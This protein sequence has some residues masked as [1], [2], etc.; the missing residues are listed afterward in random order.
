MKK[1]KDLL[2]FTSLML[3]FTYYI[4]KKNRDLKNDELFNIKELLKEFP[5][6]NKNFLTFNPINDNTTFIISNL[7]DVSDIEKYFLK[8]GQLSK[9]E[10]DVFFKNLNVIKYLLKKDFIGYSKQIVS[11]KVF[12]VHVINY[13]DSNILEIKKNYFKKLPDI[14]ITK[15]LILNS[16]F[17]NSKFKN[18]KTHEYSDLFSFI[19]TSFIISSD[20][21]SESKNLS[22]IVEFIKLFSS[23]KKS[24][25]SNNSKNNNL[26]FAS[27]MMISKIIE[28]PNILNKSVLYYVSYFENIYLKK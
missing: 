22:D 7:N 5:I 28:N 10:V 1:S 4:Y 24:I 8:S 2:V 18:N 19:L 23:Y 11:N 3:V 27:N 12:D 21:D 9:L 25:Y 26:D 6:I 14:Y 13:N 17:Y 20:L 16:I 15:S